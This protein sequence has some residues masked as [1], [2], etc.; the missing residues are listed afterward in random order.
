MEG[1][2]LVLMGGLVVAVLGFVGLI[3]R[4][5]RK[6]A[7][8]QRWSTLQEIRDRVQRRIG[9]VQKYTGAVESDLSRQARTYEQAYLQRVFRRQPIRSLSPRISVSMSWKALESVGIET[10]EDLM[11]F[12]GQFSHIQGIGQA[13][14]QALRQVRQELSYERSQ[15]SI[16]PPTVHGRGDVEFRPVVLGLKVLEMR[17]NVL[18]ELRR[19]SERSEQV[20]ARVPVSGS[21]MWRFWVGDQRALRE[22]IDDLV[23]AFEELEGERLEEM[24]AYLENSPWW[25]RSIEEIAEVYEAES[26]AVRRLLDE[27]IRRPVRGQIQPVGKAAMRS[28][29]GFENEEDFC[30]RGLDP[31]MDRLG[32]R[33]EREYTIRQRIGSK[34]QTL[35]VD[36][37]LKN[38]RGRK[39]ALLE[40][41]RHIQ[42]D[43]QLQDARDQALSYALFE[44]LDAVM[45]AAPEGLWLYE[46]KRREMVF[47]DQYEIEEAYDEA[48]NL[49]QRILVLAGESRRKRASATGE[50]TDSAGRR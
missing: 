11:A 35:Y 39:V 26:E 34:E 19:L 31:L 7:I 42:S 29:E 13:R 2:L 25:D 37:M 50:V 30:D 9:A 49:R 8:G 15:M 38:E 48:D 6:D 4:Q 5:F 44:G 10:V 20:S 40:A 33:F 32:F 23:E 43:R 22:E 16:P 18:P 46:R 24:E 47:Q 1:L 45:V 41:K 3:Y 17:R 14:A 28:G 12:R 36:F 27:M 21:V